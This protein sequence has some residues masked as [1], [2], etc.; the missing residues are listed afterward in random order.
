MPPR[1]VSTGVAFGGLSLS[2]C[3]RPAVGDVSA[4]RRHRLVVHLRHLAT[5]T[6]NYYFL[7]LSARHTSLV[8]PTAGR[9]ARPPP[10]DSTERDQPL[11]RRRSLIFSACLPGAYPA[12]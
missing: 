6:G 4:W 8:P 2:P 10:G 7:I 9:L 1:A 11:R 5:F 12:A 3:Y